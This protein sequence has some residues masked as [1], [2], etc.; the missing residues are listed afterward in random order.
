MQCAFG[1]FFI[2]KNACMETKF[3]G[4]ILSVLGIAGLIVALVNIYNGNVNIL[5]ISGVAGA[6]AFFAGIRLI[7]DG[8]AYNKKV[9]LP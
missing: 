7:P 8:K 6:F 2:N 9:D 4:I 3:W 5:I 1:H